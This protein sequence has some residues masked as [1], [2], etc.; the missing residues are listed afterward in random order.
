MFRYVM[1]S[2]IASSAAYERLQSGM[3]GTKH[4]VECNFIS[5]LV[6]MVQQ[7]IDVITDVESYPFVLQRV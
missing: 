3:K 7:P 6:F 2:S 4:I 5:K 1:V